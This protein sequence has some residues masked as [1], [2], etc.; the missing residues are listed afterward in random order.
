MKKL[1]I[2][3]LVVVG[4]FLL[5]K[6]AFKKDE[7]K[8]EEPKPIAVSK[9]SSAFNQSVNNVL[10]HY[11]QMTEGFVNWDQQV[12]S[13]S[14]QALK[15]ALDSFSVE[16]LKFDATIYETALFPLNNAKN[17]TAIIVSA[18]DWNE[19][20]RALQDLSDNL[21]NL[22]L[23]VKY[24]QAIVYWQEC[25]MAF[26]DGVAGYWLSN[27]EEVVNPYL[28][29]K[30]PKYGDTMLNCGETKMKIDFTVAESSEK[31]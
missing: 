5:Y 9:H 8:E 13:Q 10:D 25:P 23:T 28:G 2:L 12:V 29:T 14:S 7:P 11:F 31:I 21:R 30:D 3:L 27:K 15:T 22:L 6:Y 4:A 24:D 16:E 17:N 26:G 18:T 1:L 19:R 20:R